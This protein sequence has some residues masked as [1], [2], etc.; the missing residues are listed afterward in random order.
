MKKA[1]LFLVLAVLSFVVVFILHVIFGLYTLGDIPSKLVVTRYI[2][3][4]LVGT[5]TLF[6]LSLFG[7]KN[8]KKKYLLLS[9]FALLP[10]LFHAIL[11]IL[12]NVLTYNRSINSGLSLSIL[13]LACYA[14]CAVPC[15][16]SSFIALKN[17][18]D[19]VTKALSI[20]SIIL[21]CIIIIGAIVILFIN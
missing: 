13:V 14:I 15:I 3:I 21:W 1:L 12:A 11:I 5:L 10:F 6:V 4:S 9:V 19:K 16:I 17:A 7:A 2:I 18:E 20:I 8:K